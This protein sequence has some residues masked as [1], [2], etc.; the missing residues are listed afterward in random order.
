M[1]GADA[2]DTGANKAKQA[3]TK[4][5]RKSRDLMDD[6]VSLAAASISDWKDFEKRDGAKEYTD[7]ELIACFKKFDADNSG[8]IDHEELKAVRRP[9]IKTD[10]LPAHALPTAAA[11]RDCTPFNSFKC[12]STLR[13]AGAQVGRAR[14][15]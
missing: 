9:S 7:D 8:R 2:V 11:S 5:R 12:T 13:C 3:A 6:L 4:V 10:H 1:A 15:H 14:D